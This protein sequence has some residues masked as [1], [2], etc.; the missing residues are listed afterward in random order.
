MILVPE[1]D[2]MLMPQRNHGQMDIKCIH[3][4]MKSC[5]NYYSSRLS[6]LTPAE[7]A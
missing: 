2:F 6:S 5:P 1:L 7:S 3:I 4:L